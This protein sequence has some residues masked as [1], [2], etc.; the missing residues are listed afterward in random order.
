M[1]DLVNDHSMLTFV[2][3]PSQHALRTPQYSQT[4]NEWPYYITLFADITSSS[5]HKVKI[6][7]C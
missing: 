7:S 3:S 6:S 2:G 5:R 1:A 4:R